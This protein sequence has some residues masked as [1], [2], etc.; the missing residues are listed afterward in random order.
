M[1]VLSR[2]LKERVVIG[3]RTVVTVLAVRGNRVVLGVEAPEEVPVHRAELA[4]AIAVSA[5]RP[6]ARAG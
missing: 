2:K 3:G 5:D 1:L 6:R 4:E